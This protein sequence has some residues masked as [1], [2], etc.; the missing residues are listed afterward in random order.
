MHPTLDIARTPASLGGLRINRGPFAQ[1]QAV[2]PASA[3]PPIAPAGTPTHHDVSQLRALAHSAVG[4][5]RLDDA[6]IVLERALEMAPHDLEVI[7]DLAALSL[8]LDDAA[9]A[10]GLASRV[11]AGQPANP[12][13]RFTQAFALRALGRDDEAREALRQLLHGEVGDALRSQFPSLHT[14][15]AAELNRLGDGT[16]AAPGA[17]GA[18]VH[19]LPLDARFDLL[20]KLLYV[21]H[22]RQQLPGWVTVDVPTLYRRHMHMHLH[23]RRQQGHPTRPNAAPAPTDVDEAM[24]RFDTLI[25]DMAAHGCDTTQ[26]VLMGANGLPVDGA[27]RLAVA[28]ALGL[29]A[30]LQSVAEDGLRWDLDDFEQLGFSAEDRNVMLRT[31]VRLRGDAARIVLLW[32]PVQAH[33]REL[34]A[35][36]AREMVPVGSRTIEL[37]REGFEELVRDVHAFEHGPLVSDAIE[38]RISLLRH[39]P[40]KV[41][42]VWLEQPEGEDPGATGDLVDAMRRGLDAA[43]PAAWGITADTAAGGAATRHLMEI[44]ASEHNLT[45]LG[46]R[47]LPDTRALQGLATLRSM[48]SSQHSRSDEV[49]VVGGAALAALGARPGCHLEFVTGS[50]CRLAM[51]EP[52]ATAGSPALRQLDGPYA[53]SFGPHPAPSNDE[54]AVNPDLHVCVRGVHVAAASVLRDRAQHDAAQQGIDNLARLAHLGDA[55]RGALNR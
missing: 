22:R 11:L 2:P 16:H 18:V 40:P 3:R 19:R 17:Q 51:P 36:L 5:N 27:H 43:V 1:P 6:R 33:W 26:P 44:L 55:I 42:V 20:V 52:G 12:S 46:R 14:L 8:R 29:P 32:S 35:V 9:G 23:L 37:P 47:R 39:H 31:W 7:S 30:P 25:D 54:L 28:L 38:R 4:L 13:A 48:M 15:A 21:L 10:L 41:R 50:T 24:Q 45:M 49:C 34:E 53:R